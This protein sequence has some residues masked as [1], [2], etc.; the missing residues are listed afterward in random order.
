MF[1]A[2]LGDCVVD[3]PLTCDAAEVVYGDDTCTQ[4]PSCT[5]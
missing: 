2:S 3:D 5:P 4:H 1:V